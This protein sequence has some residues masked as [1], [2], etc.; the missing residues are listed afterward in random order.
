MTVSFTVPGEPQG[1]GRPRFSS[2]NGRTFT[3]TPEKT[4]LYENLVATEYDMQADGY[5][6]PDGAMIGM[7]ICA[8]YSIPKSA[9]KR[10]QS[11]MYAGDIK[12]TKKPDADNVLKCVAD[13]LNGI[14]YRDDAQIVTATIEKLYSD[15][16]RVEVTLFDCT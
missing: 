2:R 10:K 8:Y 16:P 15:V 12:P 9:S 11:A 13:S 3:H 14:A 6:F 4:V 1:K 5:R 7:Q